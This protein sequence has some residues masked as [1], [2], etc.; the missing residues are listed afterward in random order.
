ML[1]LNLYL[2]NITWV[3][4]DLRD[5]G[6]M[7][8]AHLSE[9]SLDQIYE[10][11]I[12]PVKPKHAGPRA[13]RCRICLDHAKRSMDRPE[14]EEYDEQMMREPESFVVAFLESFEG[15]H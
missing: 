10:S 2:H 13:E 9:H 3:L 4:N 12:H 6:L 14:D 11:T 7:S 5:E 15:G 1:F 8:T